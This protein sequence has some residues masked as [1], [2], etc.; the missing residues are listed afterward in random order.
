VTGPPA[1]RRYSFGAAAPSEDAFAC[2]LC[3]LRFTHGGQVCASCPIAVGCD[4]VV[5]CPRCGYQ[6][7][8]RSRLVDGL[9]ALR[10]WWRRRS[11]PDAHPV[12]T[13]DHLRAGE[14]GTVLS[15]SSA[16]AA[17]RL[18]LSHLGLA[19]GAEVCLEQSRPAA[20]VRVGQT[21]IALQ[22]SIA[23]AVHVRRLG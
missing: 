15:V 4:D 22:L 6:F 16:D 10:E 12:R 21:T 20:V 23:R 5:R 8:R 13:L 3:G 18:K 7:P 11:A 17:M 2:A 9:R 19:P 14:W 1:P